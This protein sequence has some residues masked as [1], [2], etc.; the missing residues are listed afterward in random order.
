[1]AMWQHETIAQMRKDSA[2]QAE[3][4]QS[5]SRFNPAQAAKHWHSHKMIEANLQHKIGLRDLARLRLKEAKQEA[6]ALRRAEA[7]LTAA[8]AQALE[9]LYAEIGRE[10]LDI[11]AM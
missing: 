9:E 5:V 6:R 8:Q 3:A 11:E 10:L 1:M 4:A 7:P 2:A